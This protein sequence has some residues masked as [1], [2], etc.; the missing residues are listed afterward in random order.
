[1]E[2]LTIKELAVYLPYKVRF[3]SELD[4]AYDDFGNQPVWRLDGINKL[5]GDYCLLPLE[6]N[7]AYPIQHCKLVLI[8]LSDLT[9]SLVKEMIGESICDF[10][11]DLSDDF[12]FEVYTESIGW[13]G[14]S[15]N[16]YNQF[17]RYH[18][19]VFGL[20]DKNLAIDLNTL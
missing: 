2:Q 16:E 10:R 14:L 5:Y 9:L 11:F 3:I 4:K 12:S 8:P 6:I 7:D 17:F 18:F 19:D 20:I 1:M 13:V 15:Y